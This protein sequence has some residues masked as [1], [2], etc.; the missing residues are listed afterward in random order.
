MNNNEIIK[1]YSEVFDC[2]INRGKKS[3]DYIKDSEFNKDECYGLFLLFS[4]FLAYADSYK[5]LLMIPNFRG[6]QVILRSLLECYAHLEYMLEKNILER[7]TVYQIYYANERIEWLKKLDPTSIIGKE[8]NSQLKKTKYVSELSLPNV[9]TSKE[10]DSIS[11]RL[12]QP[13]Y[14]EIYKKIN[15]KNKKWYSYNNGPKKIKNLFEH[16]GLNALYEIHYKILSEIAHASDAYTNNIQTYKGEIVISDIHHFDEYSFKALTGLALSI[17]QEVLF[18][19]TS[20]ILPKYHERYLRFLK[21]IYFPKK[22]KYFDKID[23][24]RGTSE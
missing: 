7:A 19:Y 23:L 13:P 20:K 1:K 14:N 18:Q 4:T 3:F 9:N 24:S 22:I 6:M 17:I 21:N 12:Q 5:N 15:M 11:K 8:F 10:I 2:L 16:L